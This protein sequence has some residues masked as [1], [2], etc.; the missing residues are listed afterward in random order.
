MWDYTPIVKDHFLNPRNVGEIPDADAVGEVGS[1]A[2]GDA[3]TRNVDLGLDRK[4][5]V[6]VVTAPNVDGDLIKQVLEGA[7]VTS[8]TQ[9]HL[10]AALQV[11]GVK[12]LVV[13]GL[14]TDYCVKAT[15]IDAAGLGFRTT[16][17]EDACRGVGLQP[18]DTVQVDETVRVPQNFINSTRFKGVD[19]R[20]D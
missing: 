4:S 1:L 12:R 17:V 15:A 6:D 11:L 9:T 2:C 19:F 7:A 16:L 13:V 18:D 3:R 20:I 10:D 14:A 5:I 8:K